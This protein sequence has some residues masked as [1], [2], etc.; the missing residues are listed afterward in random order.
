MPAKSDKKK[1]KKTLLRLKKHSILHFFSQGGQ[2]NLP[3][4]NEFLFL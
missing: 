1:K 2:L 3:Q 4:L